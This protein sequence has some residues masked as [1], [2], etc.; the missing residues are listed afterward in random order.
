MITGSERVIGHNGHNRN[1]YKPE[2]LQTGRATDQ[3]G[4]KPKRPQTE[5]TRPKQPQTKRPQTERPQTKMSTSRNGHT[6]WYPIHALI[7][8]K[9]QQ[10]TDQNVL[11]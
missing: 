10:N 3:T 11:L 5:K 4:H 6:R 9:C 7:N 8:V 1:D 2:Q